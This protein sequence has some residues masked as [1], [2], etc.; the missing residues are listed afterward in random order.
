MKNYNNLNYKKFY[1]FIYK[2]LF[3]LIN[4][5]FYWYIILNLC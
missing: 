4:L 2:N 5:T 3:K 1:N